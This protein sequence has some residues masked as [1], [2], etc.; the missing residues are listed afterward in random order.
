MLYF[1]QCGNLNENENF[2]V[3][4]KTELQVLQ[5]LEEI[6]VSDS[7]DVEQFGDSAAIIGTYYY[8]VE[9]YNSTNEEHLDTFNL[10]GVLYI[11]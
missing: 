9:P 8:Q 5:W 2:I 10:Y 11:E 6:N 4:A 1:A 3:D 7:E